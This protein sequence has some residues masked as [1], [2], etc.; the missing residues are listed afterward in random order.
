MM[1]CLFSSKKKY[2]I[3]PHEEVIKPINTIKIPINIKD[4]NFVIGYKDFYTYYFKLSIQ[5]KTCI[6]LHFEKSGYD[7]VLKK[8]ISILKDLIKYDNCE[9]DLGNDTGIIKS[10]KDLKNIIVRGTDKKSYKH[11]ITDVSQISFLNHGDSSILRFN[12]EPIAIF[13]SSDIEQFNVYALR[14][15]SLLEKHKKITL[16]TDQVLYEHINKLKIYY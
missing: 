9:L 11:I 6:S 3:L 8:K 5:D 1:G 4:V 12:E 10:Y 7:K 15:R 13:T 2:E 16:E 14:L